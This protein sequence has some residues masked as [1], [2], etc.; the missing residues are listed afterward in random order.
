[1]AAVTLHEV[2]R[3]T[4]LSPGRGVRS[5]DAISYTLA[6]LEGLYVRKIAPL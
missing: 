6:K 1:M 4:Y 5:L 3:T 2:T